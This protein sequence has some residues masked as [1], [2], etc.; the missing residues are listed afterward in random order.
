MIAWIKN[1]LGRR[2]RQR[3]FLLSLEKILLA[4]ST[5]LVAVMKRQEALF[6]VQANTVKLTLASQRQMDSLDMLL[7][8]REEI[9][10]DDGVQKALKNLKALYA[11]SAAN[12]ERLLDAVARMESESDMRSCQIA[13]AEEALNELNGVRASARGDE[14]G[15]A[16]F[17]SAVI[18]QIVDRM[19]LGQWITGTAVVSTKLS[20]LKLEFSEL[21]KRKLH[22]LAKYLKPF[23]C[24]LS[25]E[26]PGGPTWWEK[27]KLEWAIQFHCVAA[28]AIAL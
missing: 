28:K 9:E 6:E 16:A 19:A 12:R 25:G 27:M 3:R 23:E 18:Q 5:T 17:S 13:Q 10:W 24:H 14:F 4:N 26:E 20:D 2:D 15:E 11:A 8:A 1:R 22:K 7:A 21:G